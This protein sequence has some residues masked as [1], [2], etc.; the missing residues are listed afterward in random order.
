MGGKVTIFLHVQMGSLFIVPMLCTL[1]KLINEKI[2]KSLFQYIVCKF[3]H[4][5][6]QSI[7]ICMYTHICKTT[8]NKLMDRHCTSTVI[9]IMKRKP[10]IY[11]VPPK[12]RT[13]HH[14]T[15]QKKPDS[16]KST[17]SNYQ[18]RVNIETRTY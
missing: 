5:L 16:F 9:T 12:G 15:W 8:S 7:C 17:K 3:I 2:K 18:Y 13:W 4:I 1:Q 6:L 11:F 14:M 10:C